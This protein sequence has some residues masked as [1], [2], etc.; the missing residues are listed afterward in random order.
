[1]AL[2]NR[3]TTPSCFIRQVV[4]A[5]TKEPK[6][7]FSSFELRIGRSLFHP[8]GLCCWAVRCENFLAKET[9]DSWKSF[10]CVLGSSTQD[11]LVPLGPLRA[12]YFSS[13]IKII[14][15]ISTAKLFPPLSLVLPPHSASRL[16]FFSRLVCS[17]VTHCF[18]GLYWPCHCKLGNKFVFE[19]KQ[20]ARGGARA[21]YRYYCQS[22]RRFVDPSHGF[23]LKIA[24]YD[25]CQG[26]LPLLVF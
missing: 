3:Q 23:F 18:F 21:I 10:P 25:L 15:L 13:G 17:L 5:W 7:C 26:Q 11:L 8:G 14:A 24:A 1:M 2:H 6:N 16:P 22:A 20:T 12:I 9:K 4:P 19:S